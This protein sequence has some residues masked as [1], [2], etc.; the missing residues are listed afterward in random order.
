MRKFVGATLLVFAILFAL[1]A[2]FAQGASHSNSLV[3]VFKDGHRQALNLN[4]IQRLEF[5]G[6]VPAGFISTPGPSLAR[7][8][9]KWEVGVGNGENFDITLRDDGSA[10]VTEIGGCGS[11]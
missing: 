6:A 7:F 5:P 10:A 4:D 2:A 9:G 3:I 11:W 8:L 1:P